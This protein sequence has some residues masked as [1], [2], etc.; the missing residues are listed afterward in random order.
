MIA[1]LKDWFQTCLS[2][3]MMILKDPK[4]MT[5][6]SPPAHRL[7]TATPEDL[8]FQARLYATT[9]HDEMEAARFPTGMREAFLGMQFD[10][11]TAHYMR[12]YPGAQ[13]SIIDCDGADAGRLIL[14]RS[15]DHFSIID[16]ALMPKYRGCGIGSALLLEVLAGAAAQHLPVQLFAFTGERAILLYHR[17]GFADL[18][19]DGLHTELVW[20]PPT[21][22]DN[23][24]SAGNFPI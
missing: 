18:C 12:H 11:Q 1:T 16:I 2:A 22:L 9:R 7:R 23:A 13:W 17:L 14:D 5:A 15:E 3:E 8:P 24:T 6:P 10:A 21:S 20:R 4:T 19:D